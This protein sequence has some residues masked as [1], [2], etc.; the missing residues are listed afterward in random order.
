MDHLTDP[1]TYELFSVEPVPG[2]PPTLLR[3][4]GVRT[5]VGD[6]CVIHKPTDHHMRRWPITYRADKQFLAERTCEHG[7]NHPDPDSLA[8]YR[9][10]GMDYMAV[11]TCDGCCLAPATTGDAP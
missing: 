3:T 8:Y 10:A 9:T 4:H 5:C 6:R 7:A 1:D 11:H 2:Q